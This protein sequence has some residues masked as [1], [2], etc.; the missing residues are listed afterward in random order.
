MAGMNR[1]SEQ[2]Q[3]M[4]MKT[5]DPSTAGVRVLWASEP[6]APLPS[7]P[8]TLR[9]R[10]SDARSGQALTDLPIDHERPMHL[11]TVSKD[12]SQFQH[13]HPELGDDEA[14]GVTTTFPEDGMYVLY[15]EFVYDGRRVLDRRQL[16][17]GSASDSGASLASDL[18]PKTVDGVTVKLFPPRTI[19]AGEE[20][21]FTF[22]VARDE[23][24]VTDLE[25]YLGA[26]AHVAIVSEDANDFAHVH[27]EAGEDSS[28]T[29]AEMESMRSPPSKFGPEVGFHHTFPRRG[30]YKIWGQFSYEGNVITAPFVV[31]V[32]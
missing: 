5:V 4:N 7:Q 22:D 11:I 24:P 13:I 31:E 20:A 14:Y 9:Y 18:T 3:A 8:V 28:E 19:K 12:L 27:G 16:P 23:R 25:P 1:G 6:E 2:M 29:H 32:Q 21:R 30:F 15:D 10:V 17:V 26:A